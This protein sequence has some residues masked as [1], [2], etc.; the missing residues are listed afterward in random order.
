MSAQL[1]FGAV[2]AD[3]ALYISAGALSMAAAA[4]TGLPNLARAR[5]EDL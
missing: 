5:L 1:V 4:T 2:S 3:A